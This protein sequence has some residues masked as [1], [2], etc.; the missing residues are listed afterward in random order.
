LVPN[1]RGALSGSEDE[2]LWRTPLPLCAL[3]RPREPSPNQCQSAP[4]VSRPTEQMIAMPIPDYQTLM[5]PVLR[6]AAKGETRVPDVEQQLARDLGL[7]P[8]ER[9]RLLPSGKQR[10]LHNRVHW[11]K[12]Y[13]AKAGLVISPQRGRFVASEAGRALLA[14]GPERIGVDAC[15]TTPPFASSTV[16]RPQ[17]ESLRLRPPRRRWR[18]RPRRRPKSRSKPLMPPC[19]VRYGP[20]SSPAS[21]RTAL[22]SSR[23]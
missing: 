13:L 22:L 10:V 7:T 4:P 3:R 17:T 15:S 16:A 21:W 9:D 5:L 18:S 14:A 12:F 23:A 8:E 19:K 6:L 1:E 2:A 20:I 11:A